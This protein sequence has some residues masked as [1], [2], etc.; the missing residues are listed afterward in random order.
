MKIKTVLIV[1]GL[2]GFGFALGVMTS[3][4]FAKSKVKEIRKL[5]TATGMEE[6]IFMIIN[7][8]PEQREALRPLIRPYTTRIETI[9]YE[10]REKI[11]PLMDSIR[12]QLGDNLTAEQE[13]MLEKRFRR[14][15]P[16]PHRKKKLR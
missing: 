1:L 10:S 9:R 8:D 12:L 11:R 3:G 5:G 15:G 7:A 16:P 14:K 13:E 6:G 2:L 4:R